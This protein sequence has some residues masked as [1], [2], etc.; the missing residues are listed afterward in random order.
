M[1]HIIVHCGGGKVIKVTKIT[2]VIGSF[3]CF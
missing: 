2:L 3:R 1:E